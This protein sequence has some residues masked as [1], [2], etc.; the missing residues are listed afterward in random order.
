MNDKQL[1]QTLLIP[2]IIYQLVIGGEDN[3]SKRIR[4]F[5][6]LFGFKLI[7]DG[8]KRLKLAKR[9]FRCAKEI[10]KSLSD[11]EKYSGYKVVVVLFHLTQQ[12]FNNRYELRLKD[13]WSL[14]K[15]FFV[16]DCILEME[17][18]ERDKIFNE[19]E[20]KKFE[21]SAKKQALK[22][23]EKYFIKI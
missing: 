19:T 13:D 17:S 9:T 21:K 2:Y 22:I 12:A 7:P 10:I 23:Y 14:K 8:K 15:I 16:M 18:K 3:K 1:C 6:E 11:G 4:L 20:F 5:I